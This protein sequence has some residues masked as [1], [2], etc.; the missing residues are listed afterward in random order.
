MLRICEPRLKNGRSC[1]LFVSKV[2][3]NTRNS[4]RDKH[5]YDVKDTNTLTGNTALS[6]HKDVRWIMPD[7]QAIVSKIRSMESTGR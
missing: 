7:K 1:A 6:S 4:R 3:E 5:E 2:L